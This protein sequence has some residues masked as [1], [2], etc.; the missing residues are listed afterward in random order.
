MLLT[1][2]SLLISYVVHENYK[3]SKITYLDLLRPKL[4][5]VDNIKLS[6]LH[7]FLQISGNCLY[8]QLEAKMTL[9]Q[10]AA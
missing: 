2:R 3:D 10:N 7:I 9:N 8:P 1:Y 5:N 4:M 6:N